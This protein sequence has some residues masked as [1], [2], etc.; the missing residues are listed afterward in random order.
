MLL[1][2]LRGL[3]EEDVQCPHLFTDRVI[4]MAVKIIP[5]ENVLLILFSPVW[6]AL[7]DNKPSLNHETCKTLCFDKSALLLCFSKAPPPSAEPSEMRGEGLGPLPRQ[8]AFHRVCAAGASVETLVLLRRE[9]KRQTYF[10]LLLP[11]LEKQGELIVEIAI[12]TSQP[13]RV[14]QDCTYLNVSIHMEGGKSDPTLDWGRITA[15]TEKEVAVILTP[16]TVF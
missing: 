12:S 3:S 10:P 6:L 15:P 7:G 11:S 2:R 9:I 14:W 13:H 1:F 8:S 16:L 4:I 5:L